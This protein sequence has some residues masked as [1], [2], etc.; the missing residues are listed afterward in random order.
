MRNTRNLPP[1]KASSPTLGAALVVL[2]TVLIVTLV[3]APNAWAGAKFETLYKFKGGSDGNMPQAGLIFDQT[4]NL[5]GTTFEGGVYGGG[6]VFQLTPNQN[7]GWTEHTLYSFCS[8]TNCTDGTEPFAG[9]IFDQAGNL[10]GTTQLGGAHNNSG[11]VFQLTPNQNGGWAENTLYSFC[12]RTNCADGAGPQAGLI[13]DQAGNLYG[14]T[15]GG[16]AQNGGTVFQLTPNQNRGWTEQV[17]HHFCSRVNCTDGANPG[18]ELIFDQAGNLYG[19]TPYGGAHN[20]DG[21][22]F[23]MTPN[24]NGGWTEHVLHRFCARTNCADGVQPYGVI[25]DQAGNL[26]GT[27]LYGGAQNFGTVFQLTP[28]ET[29]RWTEHVLHAFLDMPNAYPYGSLILDKAGNLYGT[30]LGDGSTTFGSV[31]EITP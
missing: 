5:Y 1:E 8:R 14:T 24:Q 16:G 30:T 23:R 26:Y 15:F 13:F 9:L 12:S 21:T 2:A 20:N 27:T 18:P 11:T 22:V 4:G 6:T 10:Y 28:N 29:G 31:F 17:L 3:Y 19:A 25:F 7:G